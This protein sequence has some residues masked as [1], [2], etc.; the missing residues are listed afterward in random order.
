MD[1][2]CKECGNNSYIIREDSNGTEIVTGLYCGKCGAWNKWL[3]KQEK[4]L[5]STINDEQEKGVMDLIIERNNYK[6]Q[7]EIAEDELEKHRRALYNISRN[8]E[9]MLGYSE[10]D[11]NLPK[12]IKDRYNSEID[13]ALKETEDELKN[14]EEI[15]NKSEI[16][17]YYETKIINEFID[18]LAQYGMK[19]ERIY[20]IDDELE[21]II[22]CEDLKEI[23]NEIKQELLNNTNNER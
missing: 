19:K 11:I 7:A 23:I 1:F 9:I 16:R 6:Q 13:R 15:I 3:D 4:L 18:R 8:Y 10:D 21:F 17:K 22:R 5:Y 2:I 20:K 14:N 12:L